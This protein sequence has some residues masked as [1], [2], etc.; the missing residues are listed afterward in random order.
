MQRWSQ[1]PR[2]VRCATCLAV[3][4]EGWIP[5]RWVEWTMPSPL[6]V[7]LHELGDKGVGI[8]HLL[9]ES[10]DRGETPRMWFSRWDEVRPHF[11]A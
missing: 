2:K 1:L 4:D 11:L 5:I 8:A 6:F 9:F 3:H 7:Q 10:L